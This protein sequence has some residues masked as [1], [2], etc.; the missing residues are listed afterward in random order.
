MK[1]P[2]AALVW[3]VTW[4][5]GGGRERGLQAAGRVRRWRAVWRWTSDQDQ[6]RGLRKAEGTPPKRSRRAQSRRAGANERQRARVLHWGGE[7]SGCRARGGREWEW[8]WRW[9]WSEGRRR[10]KARV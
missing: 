5:R 1:R 8:R 2:G 7:G 3:R 4:A 9:R 6:R 10:A